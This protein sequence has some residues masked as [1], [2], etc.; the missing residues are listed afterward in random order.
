MTHIA[1]QWNHLHATTMCATFA[2]EQQV[3]D[4]R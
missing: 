2:A 4:D 1:S 3:E